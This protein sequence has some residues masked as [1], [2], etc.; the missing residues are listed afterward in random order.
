MPWK[1]PVS[2]SVWDTTFMF[3]YRGYGQSDAFNVSPKFYIY[4]QFATDLNAMVDYV[5]KY[6][7]VMT[8]SIYGYGI[9]GGLAL[10]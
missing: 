1:M 4:A 3:D 10:A 8:C 6:H 2:S 5:K 9:G 7:T